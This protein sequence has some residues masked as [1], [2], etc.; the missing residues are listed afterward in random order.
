[1]ENEGAKITKTMTEITAMQQ[2]YFDQG[3][4]ANNSY[5]WDF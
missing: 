3:R 2:A 4:E 1:V 5:V